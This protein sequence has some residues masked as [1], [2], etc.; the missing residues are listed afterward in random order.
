MITFKKKQT[1]FALRAHRK[2]RSF[3]LLEV[4]IALSLLVTCALPMASFPSSALTKEIHLAYESQARRLAQIGLAQIKEQLYKNE[5]PWEKIPKQKQESYELFQN[6]CSATLPLAGKRLFKR[7]AS[8][9][10]SSQRERDK[11]LYLLVKAQ[12]EIQPE[13]PSKEQ[14]AQLFSHLLLIRKPSSSS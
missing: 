3:L 7:K 5:I 8:L 10:F 2:R 9:H 11:N 13:R 14:P 4:L 1:T 12:I 6:S